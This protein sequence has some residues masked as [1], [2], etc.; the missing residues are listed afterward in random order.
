M[1]AVM[2]EKAC[3]G[4]RITNCNIHQHKNKQLQTTVLGTQPNSVE[5]G[6]KDRYKISQVLLTFPFITRGSQM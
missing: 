3:F 5:E 2:E 4:P 6:N 1:P